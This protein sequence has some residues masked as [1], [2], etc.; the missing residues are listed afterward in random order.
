MPLVLGALAVGASVDAIVEITADS[1]TPLETSA[2]FTFDV[3]ADEYA[4]SKELSTIIGYIPEYN[5]NNTAV[6]ACIGKFYD[7]AGLTG[8]YGNSES[9]TKTFTPSS[10][11]AMLAFNFTSFETE[12]G[13]DYLYIYN[14]PT[15]S[16]PQ[17][18]GS[19][20]HGTTS[21]GTVISTHETGAITFRFTSDGSAVRAGWAASFECILMNE[22]PTCASNPTPA[23]NA[24]GVNPAGTLSWNTVMTATSYDVYI[25][26]GSLPAEP[27]ANVAV[28]SYTPSVPLNEFTT[29]VW[30][31]VPKNGIGSAT[32]CG[33][34]SFT[35]GVTYNTIL[36]HSGSVT[37]CNGIFMDSGGATGA[38]ANSETYTLTINPGTEGA[39][40]KV[41]FTSFDV[42][43]NTGCTY[44]YL[45]VYNGATTSAPLLGTFCGTTVPGPFTATTGSL[46]FYFKS[47]TSVPKAGWA[48]EVTCVGGTSTEISNL[49]N[50]QLYP[51]PFTS[52]INISNALKVRTVVVSNIMGQEVARI[53][54]SGNDNIEVSTSLLPTGVYLVTLIGE[55]NEMRVTKMIKK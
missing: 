42:E 25:G 2:D 15:T 21:P 6:N 49:S 19:P 53:L 5:M 28:N 24:T 41:T 48:A 37:S 20:F 18:A 35:T 8:E 22:P 29:Y 17:I 39:N 50:T 7:S 13:Y 10:E 31:V 36:M 30:K 26:E 43:S 54:N 9:F 1:E 14:G 27:T 16:S 32:D 55:A 12:S 47:D 33:T 23:N 46:T 3:Q 11:N 44:D 40:V 34:W 45:K 52:N 38:Y 4:A 51:N